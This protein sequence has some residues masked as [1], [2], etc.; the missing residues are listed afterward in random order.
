VTF[1]QVE[2]L[3]LFA[4]VM[5]LYWSLARL[6]DTGRMLQ[7]VLLVVV[8]FVFYGWV[9]PW[10]CGLL[11]FSAVL[12]YNVGLAM[13]RTEPGTSKRKWML[14]LS[15]AGNLGMLGYF[16][17]ANFFLDNVVAVS[18]AIGLQANVPS[19]QV[20]LPVGISFYTFQ[21]M[22]YTIDIYR[23]SLKP[24]TNFLD[25][26]VFVSFFPQLVAGPVERASRLLPQ[27]EVERRFDRRTFVSGVGLA[28]WGGVKKM[29]V[30]DTIAPYVDT[31]FI[32]QDPSFGM[33]A[34][35]TLGFA[36]QILA[37]FSGYTDIARGTARM[38]GFE[39]M[40]N[41]KNPYLAKNPS[42]FWRRWHISFS[43]WIRD[44]LYIPLGGS[45]G[46]KWTTHQATFGAML[47]S[48]LWHGASW[49]F[50]L[51]GAYHAT[52]ITAYRAVTR[53]IPQHIRKDPR[54]QL[55]SVPLMFVFTC[56]GWLIFRET[57]IDRLVGYLSLSPFE[58]T[59]EQSI[60][61][62]VLLALCAATGGLLVAALV[63]EKFV[64]K[65]LRDTV[66]EL[67]FRTATWSLM[68]LGMFTFTRV[69][70]NDFIY[71]QF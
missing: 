20:I 53:H 66:W 68:A 51:W 5:A 19:L 54:S 26:M 25:Y 30:A 6:K 40:L 33:V 52:L 59:E 2:F 38:L 44:Y 31:V 41:F 55:V 18:E 24:R 34:A 7:N 28:M 61:T 43:T 36:I 63:V 71:F 39:L 12:D 49:T 15:M 56:V 10:F 69:T 48:G 22:S 50:V 62:A 9:H 14:A 23:G 1:I 16:K 3:Y 57:H 37:D 29:V 27:V 13:G 60:A 70:T 58:A 35:A 45:K 67:P 21:T 32:H 47:L 42:D 46:S 65:R 4:I 17:Y 64:L 11:L 8:S